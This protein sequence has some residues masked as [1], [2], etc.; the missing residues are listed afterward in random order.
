MSGESLDMGSSIDFFR[1]RMCDSC[2]IIFWS[3]NTA[4]QNPTPM[5]RIYTLAEVTTPIIRMVAG[6]EKKM[7]ADGR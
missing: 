5:T 7:T 1:D 2:E 3:W 4:C 6:P